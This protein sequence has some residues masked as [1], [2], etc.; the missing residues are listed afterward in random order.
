MTLLYAGPTDVHH[1][2]LESADRDRNRERVVIVTY[3]SMQGGSDDEERWQLG[4]KNG[5]GNTIEL[6]WVRSAVATFT[7]TTF[8]YQ[9]KKVPSHRQ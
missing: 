5:S 3:K 9:H 8:S 1:R 4:D 2:A 6:L 7:A